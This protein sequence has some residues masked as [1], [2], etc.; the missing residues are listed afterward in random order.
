MHL[1]MYY[2]QVY[3]GNHPTKYYVVWKKIALLMR[4]QAG[5]IL[6]AIKGDQ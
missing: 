4:K 2:I 6:G 3:C 5:K 1:K